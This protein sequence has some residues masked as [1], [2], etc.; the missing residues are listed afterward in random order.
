MEQ[1]SALELCTRAVDANRSTL[2]SA[3]EG[4]YRIIDTCEDL[5]DTLGES[6]R[7]R[8][9]WLKHTHARVCR[10][11]WRANQGRVVRLDGVGVRTCEWPDDKVRPLASQC[12][13][14][15]NATLAYAWIQRGTVVAG[16][17]LLRDVDRIYA[18]ELARRVA[19]RVGDGHGETGRAK[20]NARI[21]S[22]KPKIL[23]SRIPR[24]GAG[25]KRVG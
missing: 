15:L 18:F 16:A 20:I 1:L 14:N 2:D 11:D 13:H 19:G 12:A 4:S 21:C 8:G 9:R 23:C 5:W 10:I 25:R 3:W 7:K 6:R 17:A 22:L 24:N